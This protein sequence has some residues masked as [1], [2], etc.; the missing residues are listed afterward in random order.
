MDVLQMDYQQR[1]RAVV[2]KHPVFSGLSDADIVNLTSRMT[3]QRVLGGNVIVG[4]QEP[5]EGLFLVVAGRVRLAINGD[6]G[7]EV[8]LAMLGAGEIFGEVSAFHGGSSGATATAVYPSTLL[9]LRRADLAEFVAAH[10]DVAMRLLAEMARRLRRADETIAELALCDVPERILR[11]LKA[12]AQKEGK[13]SPE[14]MVIARQPTHQE[15]ANMVGSCRETVCRAMNALCRQ[16]LL[17]VEGKTLI[18]KNRVV[19][20]RRVVARP[21]R[22]HGRPRLPSAPVKARD[23]A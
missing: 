14:G 1:I 15:L 12:L 11:R 9:V 20:E 23:C 5:G 22:A 7:R 8:T 13:E 2:A 10:P 4:Q 17:A 6:H 18:I 16:G 21:A 3:T 19:P